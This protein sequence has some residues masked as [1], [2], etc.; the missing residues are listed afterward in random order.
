MQ[1]GFISLPLLLVTI[2]LIGISFYTGTK[3]EKLIIDT[4]NKD[5]NVISNTPAE[6]KEDLEERC[7]KFPPEAYPKGDSGWIDLVGPYWSSDC[8]YAVSSITIVGRGLPPDMDP[9]NFKPNVP[10][11]IHLYNDASKTV[12][13]IYKPDNEDLAYFKEWI[14]R[15]NFIFSVNSQKYNYNIVNKEITFLNE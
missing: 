11:G 14:N 12:N 10:I 7:G 5:H 8:R 13:L 6:Q 9:K 1:K 4:S 2:L 3:Y 15:E